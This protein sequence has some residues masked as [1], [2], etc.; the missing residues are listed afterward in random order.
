MNNKNIFR[1]KTGL[2][3]MP[4]ERAIDIDDKFD[5]KIAKFLSFK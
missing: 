4:K 3:L 2:V 1:G 5:Y